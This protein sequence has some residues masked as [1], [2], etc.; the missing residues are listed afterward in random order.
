MRFFVLRLCSLRIQERL[1]A[2]F[3]DLG[4]QKRLKHSDLRK[5][6]AS[7]FHYCIRRNPV[8]AATTVEE[9]C[10]LIEVVL[11]T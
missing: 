11:N 4:P 2:L 6:G 10:K 8:K 9:A 1:R 3:R 7:H 5:Q